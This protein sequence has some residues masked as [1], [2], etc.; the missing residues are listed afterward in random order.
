MP[1]RPGPCHPW[2]L[3]LRLCRYNSFCIMG[4]L[5]FHCVKGKG[6]T[7]L[8]VFLANLHAPTHMYIARNSFAQILEIRVHP[9]LIRG[10]PL[11]LPP[12]C[13]EGEHLGASSISS[14]GRDIATVGASYCG[15]SATKNGVN[16]PVFRAEH[17]WAFRM[18]VGA[19][20]TEK[21]TEEAR[22]A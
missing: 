11:S 2:E 17:E 18:G 12:R 22:D 6:K 15:Y 16:K 13:R 8:Y 21:K 10:N 4:T 20:A 19:V 5:N 1:A 9:L 7:F 3:G 14:Q